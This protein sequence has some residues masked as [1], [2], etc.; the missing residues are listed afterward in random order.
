MTN[1]NI[2]RSAVAGYV[3]LLAATAAAQDC[4]MTPVK[5]HNIVRTSGNDVWTYA[6]TYATGNGAA[7]WYSR[8]VTTETLDSSVWNGRQNVQNDGGYGGTA[9]N[10]WHDTISA[11]YGLG[12]Y[13]TSNTHTLI[14]NTSY[15]P[16]YS[17]TSSTTSDLLTARLP[18][19]NT[20]G[21]NGVWWLDG[22]ADAN[23][24]LYNQMSLQYQDSSSIP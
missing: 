23:N 9:T 12:V 11:G 15:C 2:V 19:I 16:G 17:T 21:V 13:S 7:Y 3:I 1:N 18:V 4:S 8:V 22:G 24:L 20:L 6:Q 10:Q 14:P 5:G